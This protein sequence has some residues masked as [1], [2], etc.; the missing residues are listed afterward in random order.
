[1]PTQSV[2]E[3]RFRRFLKRY[4]FP[5]P[6]QQHVVHRNHGMRAFVD[7][8]YP[9]IG[10]AIEVDGF[11]SH[12]NRVS[13]NDDLHRQNDLVISGLRVLRFTWSDLTTE[14][15]RVA[16]QLRPFFPA[17]LSLSESAA[18]TKA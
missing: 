5:Q 9:E 1:M 10:L 11:K 3:A 12:G 15:T 2:L 18:V 4:R 8:C 17:Q 14:E 7:F 6:A 16:E 13:W